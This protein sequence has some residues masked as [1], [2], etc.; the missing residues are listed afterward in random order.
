MINLATVFLGI[1]GG[2]YILLSPIVPQM[3]WFDGH[4]ILLEQLARLF[5]ALVYV[6][7][8]IALVKYITSKS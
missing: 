4:L 3:P 2:V 6:L 5:E 8:A 7:A 1:V